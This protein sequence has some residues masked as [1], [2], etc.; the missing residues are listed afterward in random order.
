MNVVHGL[1]PHGN[2]KTT[3]ILPRRQ[4]LPFDEFDFTKSAKEDLKTEGKVSFVRLTVHTSLT[5]PP[6]FNLA[7]K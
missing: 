5:N 2:V 6:L 4:C 1:G 7:S 3:E